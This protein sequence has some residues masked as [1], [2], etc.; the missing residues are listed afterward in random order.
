MNETIFRKYDI[1]GIVDKEITD[2]VAVNIGKAFGTMMLREGRRT[3]AVGRDCRHS[4]ERFRD[5]VVQGLISTGCNVVDVG[6]VPTPLLYFAIHHLEA[7]GGVMITASHNPPEYNGFK[8]NRGTLSMFDE[9]ILHVRDLILQGEFKRGEGFIRE[10]DVIETYIKKIEGIIRLKR[11][12]RLA[13]DAGNGMSGLVA[14]R[15]YRNLGCEVTEYFTEPDGD[16]PNH[17]PD[18][19]E[20]ENMTD[21]I[22]EIEKGGYDI[23]IGFDGD[24]DRVG[25]VDRDGTLL[26]GD[27]LVILLAR[28]VL[29]RLPGSTI[30]FDVKCSQN[31]VEDIARHAGK[32]LMWRTGHSFI[33]KKMAETG[34]PMAGEMSG[35]I[36][37]NDRFFGFDDAVYAGARMME[38][39]A[40]D[41]RSFM[42][43]LSDLPRVYNTP[44]IKYPCS[45]AK[46]FQ[47]V[48]KI[49]AE[50]RR[51]YDV[52]DIDGVRVDFGDGWG[53]V[54]ASNTTPYIILRFEAKSPERLA[55]IR[56]QVTKIVSKYAD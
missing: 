15:L 50:F 48:D 56:E 16:F 44:E 1:R 11:P 38:I 42:E 52:I 8:L 25:I 51:S 21:L 53:L 54:R 41:N 27:Q 10:Q 30:I 12:L 24:G 31:L 36:F 2:E 19:T 34:A 4:S 14:P 26:F 23:G 47:A 39:A 32:P 46:K 49:A 55:E 37:F 3:I 45:E 43:M 22:A 18:P 6:M 40:A 17:H 35:H 5:D 20:P 13:V 29:A 33:K 28:E 9:E 7:D